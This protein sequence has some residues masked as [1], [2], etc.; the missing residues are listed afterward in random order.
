MYYG[1]ALASF[2]YSRKRMPHIRRKATA[3][4]S[5]RGGILR[6]SESLSSA[7]ARRTDLSDF[8]ERSTPRNLCWAEECARLYDKFYTCCWLQLVA[9]RC[10]SPWAYIPSSFL[11]PTH[12]S[13]GRKCEK[14]RKL[15]GLDMSSRAAVC[16]V[17]LCV[18]HINANR[19]QG[20]WRSIG[21]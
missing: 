3:A 16:R 17:C 12:L 14:I 6:E 19:L 15:L 5:R 9:N 10:V 13:G 2:S 4:L 7:S 1:R 20:V 11:S 8:F 18:V 21:G